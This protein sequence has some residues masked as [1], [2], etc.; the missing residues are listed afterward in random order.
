MIFGYASGTQYK[1]IRLQ[2]KSLKDFGATKIYRDK[3]L[4][5][6]D[7]RDGL[8]RMMRKVKEGDLVVSCKNESIFSSVNE[9]V[10]LLSILYN[11]NA[12]YISL[13]N[14]QFNKTHS[15]GSFLLKV[16]DSMC[17]F[18]DDLLTEKKSHV[19]CPKKRTSLMGRPKGIQKTT[20]H[21][22]EYANYLFN[23]KLETIEI[24]CLKANLSKSS[25]YR[26]QSS[27]IKS[28]MIGI[29]A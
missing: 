14:S 23:V 28:G 25:Y 19:A 3:Y 5:R 22:Y 8:R 18:Q 11:K 4:N 29:N 20:L 15:N 12:D 26:I 21:K 24:A 27:L 1:N 17:K 13:A 7:Y 6:N 9:M 10:K 16:F 2:E